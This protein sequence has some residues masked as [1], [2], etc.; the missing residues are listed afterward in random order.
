MRRVDLQAVGAG[1]LEGDVFKFTARSIS[2]NELCEPMMKIAL[3]QVSGLPLLF[4]HRHPAANDEKAIPIFGRSVAGRIEKEG[5]L[6]YLV[7]DYEIPL[8][9][10]DGHELVDKQLF[11]A[12]VKESA[13]AKN[14]I[15]IS[16]AFIQHLEDGKAYWV[17]VYEASGTHVPACVKCRHVMEQHENE[18]GE[19]DLPDEGK[20]KQTEKERYEKLEAQLEKLTKEKTELESK[21]DAAEKDKKS[22][23][24]LK[25]ENDRF[26]AETA[27]LTASVTTL[28]ERLDYAETK[29]PLVDKIVA[30]EKRPEL[31]DFYKKQ[32]LEYLQKTALK[33]ESQANSPSTST[34]DAT[35]AMMDQAKKAKLE[36]APGSAESVKKALEQVAPDLRARMVA[37]WKEQGLEVGGADN[38]KPKAQ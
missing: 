36:M 33:W 10:P 32:T 6:R 20:D 34:G 38:G 15:G 14:P 29:K 24:S 37:F 28:A 35:G 7:I 9:A 12:W 11:A 22:Y 3:S 13:E 8:K 2:S 26:A 25:A 19:M 23:E 4:R 1:R 30:H 18:Q 5:D 16:L 31:E 17:D 27:R 21:L